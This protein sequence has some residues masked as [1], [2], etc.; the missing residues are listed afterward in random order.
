MNEIRI[1]RYGHMQ[2]HVYTCVQINLPGT[3]RHKSKTLILSSLRGRWGH[4]HVLDVEVAQ[5][6]AV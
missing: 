6:P 5:G 1:G 2:I 3:S 4:A